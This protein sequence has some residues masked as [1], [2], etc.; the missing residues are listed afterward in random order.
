[1]VPIAEA[2]AA[3]GDRDT[4]LATYRLAMDQAV[5]NPNSRPRAEDLTMICRSMALGAVEP[6][7]ALWAR[8]RQ[9]HQ[10]LGRPW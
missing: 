2:Y 5:I 10:G 3:M 4:A 7:A 9:I 6:D 8:M 1:M